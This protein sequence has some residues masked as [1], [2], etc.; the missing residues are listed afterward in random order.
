VLFPAIRETLK[1]VTCL[2]FQFVGAGI[3]VLSASI[4]AF[5]RINPASDPHCL[6]VNGNNCT[7]GVSKGRLFDTGRTWENAFPGA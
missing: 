4:L 3:C 7:F 6:L 5:W 1:P 2:E